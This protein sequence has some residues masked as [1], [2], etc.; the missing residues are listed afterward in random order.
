M[1]CHTWAYK[2]VE[3]PSFE[4]MKGFVLK[5]YKDSSDNLQKWIDNPQDD[6]YLD[7]LKHYKDW[8]I[9]YIKHWREVNKRRI[10]LIENGFCKEAIINRYCSFSNDHIEYYNGKFYKE[11]GFHDMFR[12]Y[13]YP[14]DKLF[15]LQ[16]TL[17][18]INN[19]ENK[20]TV[21]ENTIER[22]KEFW[23]K[24]PDGMIDFG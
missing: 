3:A 8:T 7:M 20:C 12:K 1:G 6:E 23:N 10:R 2:R 18:Y 14:N 5:S 4:N 17:D 11:I 16:E 9:E 15:S 21:Y 22:L 19:P 24:Y 13:G